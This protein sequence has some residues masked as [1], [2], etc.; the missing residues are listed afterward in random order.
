MRC[1]VAERRETIATA[2]RPGR[3]S[4]G[5]RCGRISPACVRDECQLR[6]AGL[7]TWFGLARLACPRSPRTSTRSREARTQTIFP[8]HASVSQI[9]YS[10]S[11]QLTAILP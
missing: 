11:K 5:A 6:R 10:A 1:G 9:T 3:V 2:G 7:P 8:Q 4:A